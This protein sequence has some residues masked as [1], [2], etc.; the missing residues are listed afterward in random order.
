ME[1]AVS[2]IEMNKRKS[3]K[4]PL[5]MSD[6]F[7]CH[8]DIHPYLITSS[9]DHAEKRL[10]ATGQF[11]TLS[12]SDGEIYPHAS[13]LL[14]DED[15]AKELNATVD[16]VVSRFED[17]SRR[18]KQDESLAR[19]ITLFKNDY[20]RQVFSFRPYTSF[21]PVYRLDLAL[22][23]DRWVLLEI[24]TGCPG[25]E[26]DGGL[27][28]EVYS[29]SPVIKS[30]LDKRQSKKL[31]FSDP[32]KEHLSRILACYQ[33]QRK[34]SP[35][36]LP[37][38][39]TIGL[40]TS[41][42]QADFLL[43]ECH[44]IA[45]YYQKGGFKTLVGDLLDIE[46]R[47]GR[48][49]LSGEEIH[50][51]FRKFSTESFFRRMLESRLYDT[52]TRQKIRTLFEAYMEG[53]F[54]MVNPLGSTLMQD[55]GLLALALDLYPDLKPIIPETHILD[56][57]LIDTKELGKRIQ[58]GKE[59]ILKGRRSYGGKACI[60][61]PIEVSRK[62]KEICDQHPGKWIAQRRV[63]ISK[64]HFSVLDRGKPRTGSF[65][66]IVGS[67]G[68]SAY[69][70]VGTGGPKAPINADQG[71]AAAPLIVIQLFTPI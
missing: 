54:C 6:S 36:A 25:G 35:E 14:L 61:Q 10:R 39:P 51:V 59:F 18:I 71:S 64:T 26:L 58:K 33:Q 15:S 55:K 31:S 42:T 50:L 49:C 56:K 27:L 65:P 34:S 62:F 28:A 19:Q 44:G 45:D 20:E 17:L 5:R 30:F 24:N 9:L 13:P 46:I 38:I 68:R 47:S 52:E 12:M 69:V 23:G 21:L 7:R 70:R 29:K 8:M 41:T 11:R 16:L 32:R 63:E 4:R 57:R 2:Q 48:P 1:H 40:I 43:P 37:E 60:L 66:F 3:Q 22:C 53:A 67:F